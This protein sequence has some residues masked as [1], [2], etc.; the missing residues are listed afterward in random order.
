ME[1]LTAILPETVKCKRSDED[2]GGNR[3]KRQ[4]TLDKRGIS[5]KEVRTLVMDYVIEDMLPLTTV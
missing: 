5:S 4:A 3:A 1:N 2:N